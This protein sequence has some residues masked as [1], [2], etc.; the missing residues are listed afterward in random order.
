MGK[1][2]QAFKF[3]DN[4]KEIADTMALCENEKKRMDETEKNVMKNLTKLLKDKR[5]CFLNKSHFLMFRTF[6]LSVIKRQM[7]FILKQ[8]NQIE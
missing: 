1:D 7:N 4:V 3:K 6:Y 8:N 5:F 2:E